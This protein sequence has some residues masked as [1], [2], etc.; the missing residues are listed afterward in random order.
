M[1][2]KNKGQAANLYKYPYDVK[3]FPLQSTIFHEQTEQEMHSIKNK[4][5]YA[6]DLEEK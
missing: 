3:I 2:Y 1:K 6:V 4:I 5:K